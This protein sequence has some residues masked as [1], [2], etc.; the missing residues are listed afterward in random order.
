VPPYLV[1]EKRLSILFLSLSLS[2]CVCVKVRLATYGAW[3]RSE[4]PYIHMD[5][6]EREAETANLLL[7]AIL[8]KTAEGHCGWPV[9]KSTADSST[10]M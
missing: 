5:D 7:D 1:R 4:S 9:L 6:G 8:Q 3:D 10:S 2:L